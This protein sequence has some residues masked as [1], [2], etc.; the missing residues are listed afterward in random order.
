MYQLRSF[1][2]SLIYICIYIIYITCYNIIYI[3]IYI[4]LPGKRRLIYICYIYNICILN[5]NVN[6]NFKFRFS[7][8]GCVRYDL[9][10][11]LSEFIFENLMAIVFTKPLFSL[12]NLYTIQRKKG[13]F[14]ASFFLFHTLVTSKSILLASILD[15]SLTISY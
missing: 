5:R 9:I 7:L 12:L 14:Y 8:S 1:P 15:F 6:N 3:F 11:G 10:Y 13:S 4:K 2:I